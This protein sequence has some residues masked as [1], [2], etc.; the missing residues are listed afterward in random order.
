MKKTLLAVALLFVSTG[1]FAQL[2]NIN[3]KAT[4]VQHAVTMKQAIPSATNNQSKKAVVK[5]IPEGA[6]LLADF[7]D[8]TKYTIGH[9]TVHT[10]NGDWTDFVIRD[11]NNYSDLTE[12][13][14]YYYGLGHGYYWS[15]SFENFS[16]NNGFAFMNFMDIR[17][18]DKQHA[19]FVDAYVKFNDPV[20]TYGKKGIDIYVSLTVRKFNSDQYFIDWSRDENFTTYDSMEFNIKNVDVNVNDGIIG[21][22]HITLPT[23]TTNVPLIV[24]DPTEVTYFRIRTFSP[25]TTGQPHGYFFLIDDVAWAETPDARID[26][27]RLDF[28]GGY[29]RI[30]EFMQVEPLLV[31][32]YMRNTG[33]SDVYDVTLQNAMTK[34][35]IIEGGASDGSDT[36]TYDFTGATINE[37][38]MD[39][40]SHLPYIER[41]R[42]YKDDSVDVIRNV[43]YVEAY[44]E[45]QL[46]S[47]AG[48]YAVKNTIAYSFERDG[49]TVDTTVDASEYTY[50]YSVVSSIEEGLMTDLYRWSR[51]ASATRAPFKY[52]LLMFGDDAYLGDANCYVEGYKVCLGFQGKAFNNEA[53][54]HGMELIPAMNT[55]DS[56]YVEEGSIIRVSLNKLD[57]SQSGMETVFVPVTS[58]GN[59]PIVSAPYTISAGEINTMPNT[60]LAT[61][62][63]SIYVPF[64]TAAKLEPNTLYYACYE[65]VTSGRFLVAESHL[66]NNTFMPG[67]SVIPN[68]ERTLAANNIVIWSPNITKGGAQYSWGTFFNYEKS[69]M[70][71]LMVSESESGLN[72]IDAT[73]ASVNMYPNPVTTTA[74][75]NYALAESG[76]VTITVTDIMGRTVQ[77]INK[78]QQ[79]AG[80]EHQATISTSELSNGTY[81]CTLNV[82]GAKT[83]TKFVVNK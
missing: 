72:D 23:N 77:T 2:N 35:T 67:L 4:D 11:S 34:G 6:T 28:M 8:D 10:A 58:D 74:K 22:Y 44:D 61:N 78:G 73:V 5:A 18:K 9:T 69:P 14:T 51:D 12:Y 65:L 55:K 29:S 30:P 57:L 63:K 46:N 43:Q 54:A 1:V 82:N 17:D 39:T 68:G 52:G 36:I 13:F 41:I 53:Y 25:P 50:P 33:T 48:R 59:K 15:S 3:K 70:M 80:I 7:S 16:V 66:Y 40:M 47:G 19:T 21:T 45:N 42:D 60:P 81:F 49:A 56:T 79:S 64:E 83:T 20:E 31:G 24:D 37:G 38:T 32:A 62:Y 76:K 27:I 71:R 75:L 26:L